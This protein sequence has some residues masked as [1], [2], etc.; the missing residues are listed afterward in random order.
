[1]KKQ[2][3]SIVLTNGKGQV[4]RIY[5]VENSK[6]VEFCIGLEDSDHFLFKAVDADEIIQAI[7]E[8]V[9]TSNER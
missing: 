6:P 3:E 8:V 2:I 9:G 7:Q 5:Q 4:L 1:M